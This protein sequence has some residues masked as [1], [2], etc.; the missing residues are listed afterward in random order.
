MV[1]NNDA[2][3]EAEVQSKEE[4]DFGSDGDNPRIRPSKRQASRGRKR[5]PPR[6]RRRPRGY[7]DD[8]ELETDE[9]EE[10]EEIGETFPC[11]YLMVF[12]KNRKP[13]S[14]IELE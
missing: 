4:S 8:E 13:I 12:C 11:I 5:L 1:S 6:R 9:E 10:E 2:E 7:S 3:S 14:A